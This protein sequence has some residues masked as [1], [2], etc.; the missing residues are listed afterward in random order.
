M[1]LFPSAVLMEYVPDSAWNERA[2]LNVVYQ[3]LSVL[4][5]L[6]KSGICHFDFD[7]SNVMLTFDIEEYD[8]NHRQAD[9]NWGKVRLIDFG[10]GKRY[11]PSDTETRHQIHSLDEYKYCYEGCDDN[12]RFLSFA[13]GLVARSQNPS[14]ASL[15]KLL[16]LLSSINSHSTDHEI[17]SIQEHSVFDSVRQ[18]QKVPF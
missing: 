14:E 17:A 3:L 10:L 6:I 16:S 11:L 18:L 13:K 2:V 15:K 1:D 8:D 5:Y 7:E 9:S 4:R 12:S